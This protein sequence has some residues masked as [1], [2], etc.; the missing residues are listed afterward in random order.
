[1][2]RTRAAVIRQ[3]SRNR[4]VDLEQPVLGI[5][6]GGELKPTTVRE[7]R[8]QTWR[9]IAEGL[10]ELGVTHGIALE[11][12]AGDATNLRGLRGLVPLVSWV[13][14]DLVPRNPEVI[15]A[16]A[17]QL[18]FADRSCDVVVTVHA[19]EQM[20]GETGKQ[21]LQE[22]ARVT[23]R[24]LI[25]LEPDYQRASWSQRLY[26]RRRDY[27]RDI[28]NPAAV[29]G[30]TLSRRQWA[31]AGNPLNRSSIFVFDKRA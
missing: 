28:V 21:V 12:G 20:P 18:P 30:L 27:I 17:V 13:G 14:C 22:I 31:V 29:A 2:V 6:P 9:L 24:G 16:D 10:A 15:R 23:R 8:T 19:L 26:M 1:M 25:S 5:L 4:G 7:I 11:V 3:Y